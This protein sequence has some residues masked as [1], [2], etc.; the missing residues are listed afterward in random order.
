MYPPKKWCPPIDE[1]KT[2][3]C[4]SGLIGKHRARASFCA[5]FTVKT[6]SSEYYTGAKVCAKFLWITRHIKVHTHLHFR[7]LDSLYQFECKRHLLEMSDKKFRTIISI[8]SLHPFSAW[9]LK[10]SNRESCSCQ[11]VTC[12]E[13]LLLAFWTTMLIAHQF[14]Y[15]KLI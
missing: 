15:V 6:F 10:D 1:P 11:F 4:W 13:H 9:C 12:N 7:L 8:S 2:N 14:E 5:I 3:K